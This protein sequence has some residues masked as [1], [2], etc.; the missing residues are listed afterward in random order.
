MRIQE[1]IL[2]LVKV[3]YS[4][5]FMQVQQVSMDKDMILKAFIILESLVVFF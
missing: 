3:L 1:L 2:Q 5:S 4:L